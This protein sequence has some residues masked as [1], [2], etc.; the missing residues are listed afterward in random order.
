MC[1]RRIMCRSAGQTFDTIKGESTYLVCMT[2]PM[3]QHSY[4]CTLTGK[5]FLPLYLQIIPVI[6]FQFNFLKQ[7]MFYFV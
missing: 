4:L 2:T 7:V 1:Y 5:Q 3:M 6:V